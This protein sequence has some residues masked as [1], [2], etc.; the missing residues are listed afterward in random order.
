MRRTK[1]NTYGAYFRRLF[2][3]L[4]IQDFSYHGLL[5]T[6]ATFCTDAG[7]DIVTTKEILGH[8][9]ISPTMRYSHKQLDTKRVAI[10][11]VTNHILNMNKK[12]K[13]CKKNNITHT[14]SHL[15]NDYTNGITIR[16]FR[17]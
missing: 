17:S 3:R 9:D 7:T 1:I 5:H 10:E 6:F 12:S 15:Q 2:K 11:L 14:C 13:L 8:S 16:N 4:G